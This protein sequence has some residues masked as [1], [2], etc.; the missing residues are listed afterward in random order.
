VLMRRTFEKQ[1]LRTQ[2]AGKKSIWCLSDF[3]GCSLRA[4]RF[5]V[6][7]SQILKRRGRG[8]GGGISKYPMT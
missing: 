6:L 3:G 1:N 5:Q 4:Q 7:K 8:D 2:R